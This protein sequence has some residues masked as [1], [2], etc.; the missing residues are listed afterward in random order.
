MH[1]ASHTICT[2]IE[3]ST[4]S[5]IFL[6]VLLNSYQ[7]LR[8]CVKLEILQQNHNGSASRR[9]LR[10]HRRRPACGQD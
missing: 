9:V 2:Q 6:I 8:P 10:H 7:S 3:L 5:F 1:H 4:V